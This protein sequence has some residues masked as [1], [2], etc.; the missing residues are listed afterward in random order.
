MILKV[1]FEEEYSLKW[2]NIAPT[3]G[4]LVGVPAVDKIGLRILIVIM[5]NLT[6]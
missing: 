6:I 4:K 1:P 5:R 2:S 3:E